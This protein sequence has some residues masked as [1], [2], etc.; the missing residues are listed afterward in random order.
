MYINT[1]NVSRDR[2]GDVPNMSIEL[3]PSPVY[4]GG[5][6]EGLVQSLPIGVGDG[7]RDISYMISAEI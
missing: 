1:Q 4:V 2:F 3:Y 5:K 7:S 6:T